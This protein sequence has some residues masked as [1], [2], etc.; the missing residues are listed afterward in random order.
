MNR[1]KKLKI[2]NIKNVIPGWNVFKNFGLNYDNFVE[3]KKNGFWDDLQNAMNVGDLM[4]KF[5]KKC[6]LV[7]YNC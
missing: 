5:V 2:K 1:H 6:R 7:N 4:N 3:K